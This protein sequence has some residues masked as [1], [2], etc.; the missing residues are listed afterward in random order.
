MRLTLEGAG[1]YAIRI[2]GRVAFSAAL[3]LLAIVQPA[4]AAISIDLS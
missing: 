1:M 3:C 4:G 2:A